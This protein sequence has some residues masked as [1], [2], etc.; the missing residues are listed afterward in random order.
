M[1]IG[2]VGAGR[3]EEV[4]A[5]LGVALQLRPKGRR[6]DDRVTVAGPEHEPLP[7]MR[8]GF[9]LRARFTEQLLWG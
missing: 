9:Y 1:L 7:A 6:G 8:R 3:I 2:L 4:T 5:H